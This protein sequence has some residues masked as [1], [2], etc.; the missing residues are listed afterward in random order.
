MRAVRSFSIQ[1]AIAVT[2]EAFLMCTC[3]VAMLSLD[4]R[5]VEQERSSFLPCI[6]LEGG[7]QNFSCCVKVKKKKI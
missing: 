6:T 4:A 1:V 5:R 3:F 2:F 7:N